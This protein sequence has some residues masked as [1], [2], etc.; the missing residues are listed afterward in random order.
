MAKRHPSTPLRTARIDRTNGSQTVVLPPGC[1]F[2]ESVRELFIRRDGETLVL[3]PRPTD[4]S[5]FFGSGLKTSADFMA[6]RE[7]MLLAPVQK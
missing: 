7:Y 2:P 4:W 6:A 3:T 1:R 5:T